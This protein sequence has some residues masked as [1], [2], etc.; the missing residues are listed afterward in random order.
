MIKI[1]S[2]LLFFGG[3][4]TACSIFADEVFTEINSF[5][6]SEPYTIDG[7]LD[8]LSG[9]LSNGERIFTLNQ[10]KAGVNQGNWQ[11]GVQARYDYLLSFNSDTARYFYELEND[12]PQAVGSQYDID[13]EA[14][15]FSATGLFLGY[16]W[17]LNEKSWFSTTFNLLRAHKTLDGRLQ[18]DWTV[19]ASGGALSSPLQLDYSYSRDLIFRE[20]IDHDNGLGYSI[21]FAGG[22]KL[23]DTWAFD[24]RVQDAIGRIFWDDVGNTVATA[25]GAAADSSGT[26]LQPTVTGNSRQGKH[27]QKIPVKTTLGANWQQDRHSVRGELFYLESTAF[28]RVQYRYTWRPKVYV[29][30]GYDFKAKALAASASYRYVKLQ[31]QADTLDEEKAHNLGVNFSLN[32]PVSF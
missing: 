2:A 11:Y 3:V 4:F 18:G 30:A 28:P 20:D 13:I 8:E 27:V 21:D 26:N 6:Y 29:G 14:S 31:L 24:Y 7:V 32:V 1:P 5:H 19:P 9:P 12:I 15:H 25:S 22:Y 23:D 17:Q 16:K 10:L